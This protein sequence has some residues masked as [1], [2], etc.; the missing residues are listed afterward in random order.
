[1]R[2]A[3]SL[4]VLMIVLLQSFF[5]N[6]TASYAQWT[7]A[8][9]DDSIDQVIYNSPQCQ[10]ERTQREDS[11]NE[12]RAKNE[13]EKRKVDGAVWVMFASQCV[14]FT[15]FGKIAVQYLLTFSSIIA[16]GMFMVA[17]F[18]YLTSRG[19]PSALAD[20]KDMLL[21]ASIGIVLIASAVVIIQV[22]DG[23]L[24]LTGGEDPIDLLPFVDIF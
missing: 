15:E 20:A 16:G 9:F 23:T 13:C 11:A 6:P 10:Q 22:L 3:Y 7:V 21:N 8:C 18:K 19:D 12:S 2:I 4:G 14:T 17:S 1:M 24:N 5:V